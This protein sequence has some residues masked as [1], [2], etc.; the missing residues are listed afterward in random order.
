MWAELGSRE[1]GAAVGTRQ[2]TA[3]AC[4]FDVGV[5]CHIHAGSIVG[6]L[7][8]FVKLVAGGVG[9]GLCL[10]RGELFVEVRGAVFALIGVGVPADIGTYPFAAASALFEVLFALFDGFFESV[11]VGFAAD[12]AL[13]LVG[14]MTGSIAPTEEAS[15][16]VEKGSGDADD[17][18]LEVGHEAIAALVAME[19][20]LESLVG[21]KVVEVADKL[22]E[23]HVFTS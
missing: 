11:I 2:S 20:E 19:L 15:G 16:G 22:D 1:L 5:G 9:F 4:G 8:F 7:G 13:D 12:G 17:R 6:L 10:R 23:R 21:G 18:G 14:G 3:G